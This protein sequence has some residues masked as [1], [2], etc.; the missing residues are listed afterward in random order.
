MKRNRWTRRL[1]CAF[2]VMG[3]IAGVALAVGTQGSQSDPLV[4]LSYL[5]EVAVPDIL[6]QVD[7]KIDAR[8]DEL[9]GQGQGIGAAFATVEA[10]AGKSL[11]LSSGSQFLVRSGTV[12]SSD[13]LLDLTSGTTWGGVGGL[14]ANHLYMAVGEGQKITVSSAAILM[15]QGKYTLG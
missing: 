3:T 9:M 7:E 2:L 6:K 11:S 1:A 10:A 4:T 8:T 13:A 14:S 5:N 15:V 12:S